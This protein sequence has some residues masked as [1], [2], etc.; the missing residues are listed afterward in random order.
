MA[1][2]H[3]A[4]GDIVDIQPLGAAL[5]DHVS[6]AF[7][8]STQLELV[9]LVLPS[10]KEMREHKVNGEITVLCIEGL[11]DFSTP[12]VTRRLAPGQLVHLAAGEP[13]ALLAVADATALL[14]ICL[15]PQ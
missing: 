12:T 3:A 1:L 11:I 9:R 13:H 2:A 6:T 15:V 7:F 10:G 4:S 5:R 14:T 8:K